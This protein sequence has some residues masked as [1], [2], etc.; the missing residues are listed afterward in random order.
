MFLP[1]IVSEPR[2][3]LKDD[4][5]LGIR[6]AVILSS[7]VLA[8][9]VVVMLVAAV[10]RPR[11]LAGGVSVLVMLPLV[12]AAYFL[13]GVLGGAALWALRPLRRWVV[14]WVAT[15]ILIAGAAY[16]SMGLI[17]AVAYV[18]GGI[19]MMDYTSPAE[20][21]DGLGTVTAIA[22]LGAGIP[23]GLWYWW[24]ERD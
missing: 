2:P 12:F 16:G 22:S 18:Y 14:G 6:Y 8:T 21:W 10:V 17:A 5:R 19:N 7:S 24:K 23:C 9:F 15:G 3:A 1:R 4:V 20:A 13:A 11:E